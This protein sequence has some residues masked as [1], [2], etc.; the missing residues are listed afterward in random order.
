[1]NKAIIM[2]NVGKTE[3]P[4]YLATGK[5]MF[6]F[7]VATTEKW[8]SKEGSPQSKTEWHSIDTFGTMAENLAK[9]IKK[10][11]KVL[12]EGKI[13]YNS[14]E[15]DGVKKYSTAIQA[16]NVQVVKWTED[17]EETFDLMDPP[18]LATSSIVEENIPF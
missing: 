11:Q 7:S 10:G 1:M 2:G 6:K 4:K 17:K 13:K 12:V 16:D 15:K 9:L 18:T 5:C 8:K 14:W 3:D